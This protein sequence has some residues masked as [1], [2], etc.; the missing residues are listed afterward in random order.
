MEVRQRSELCG[1]SRGSPGVTE[2]A[3]GSE[4]PALEPL[5]GVRPC[6]TLVL[7]F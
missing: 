1:H 3:R 6:D 7:N 4:D 5:E 2:A